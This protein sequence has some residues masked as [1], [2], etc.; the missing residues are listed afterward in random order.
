MS[1]KEKNWSF[2]VFG[3]IAFLG[4]VCENIVVMLVM[5]D[6]TG[7]GEF[8]PTLF[9]GLLIW[10]I[11]Y[12]IW[13]GFAVLLH[14]LAKKKFGFNMFSYKGKISTKN[15]LIIL[16]MCSIHILYFA[17]DWGWTLKPLAEFNGF[18]KLFGNI[19]LI[20]FTGQIIYYFFE[21][22]LMMVVIAFGQE[23]GERKFAKK[24]VPWGGILLAL[25]W[26]LFHYITKL[27]IGTMISCVVIGIY[28]GVC[29]LLLKKN[30]I[31]SWLLF[32]VVYTL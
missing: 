22:L 8:K 24:N 6:Y 15:L 14:L 9:Q 19:G 21:G 26:G 12:F 17:Y 32:F 20:V 3:I 23:Y 5:N 10:G 2:L 29:Y 16:F 18:Y 31:Y 7:V 27:D 25:T 4:F 13:G 30:A 11:T 1:A 28:F